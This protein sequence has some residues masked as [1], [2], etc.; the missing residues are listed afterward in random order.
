MNPFSLG[1]G[2]H[3]A[4]G[5]VIDELKKKVNE[6][7]NKDEIKQ[8]ATISAQ[9]EEVGTLIAEIMHEVGQD[10]VITVE[11]GKT[12]GLEKEIVKGMQFEQGYLS[13]YFVTDPTRM[14]VS[15]EKPAILVTDKKI[16]SIKDILHLLEAIAQ[17]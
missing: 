4:V 16:S 1:R 14:E 12:M 6:I 3:K 2:L 7:S 8:V 17:K 9:D 10:G 11:E 5:K 15:I 13:P